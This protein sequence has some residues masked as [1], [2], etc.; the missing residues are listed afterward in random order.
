MADKSSKGIE[1][2]VSVPTFG[3]KKRTILATHQ[4]MVTLGTPLP[5][6]GGWLYAIIMPDG[7][8]ATAEAARRYQ[9]V[10]DCCQQ[11]DIDP[12]KVLG[13][14]LTDRAEAA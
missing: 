1:H 13:R 8:V 2:I 5:N 3:V 10:Y 14:S 6:D 12:V 9:A 11:L 4:G 7:R